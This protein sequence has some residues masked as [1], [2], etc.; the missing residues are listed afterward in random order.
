MWTTEGRVDAELHQHR[1]ESCSCS[2]RIRTRG[3]DTRG[4]DEGRDDVRPLDAP[5]WEVPPPSPVDRRPRQHACILARRQVARGRWRYWP[6]AAV[7]P[8]EGQI[9]FG[10]AR[11]ATDQWASI[12]L[13]RRPRSH[14]RCYRR[15]PRSALRPRRT[16]RRQEGAVGRGAAVAERVV[17]LARVS[18]DE[19]HP[20]RVRRRSGRALHVEPRDAKAPSHPERVHLGDGDCVLPERSP[21]R[22]RLRR[23]HVRHRDDEVGRRR[24]R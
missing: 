23:A 16:V 9:R 17:S 22:H 4:C 5:E 6:D 7:Y 24:G 12:L 11:F 15:G 18:P 14:G 3:H 8:G 1:Q 2:A 13:A 20:D 21:A 19:G 10:D